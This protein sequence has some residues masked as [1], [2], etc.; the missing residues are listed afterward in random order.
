[1]GNV[2]EMIQTLLWD[3]VQV[4]C[5]EDFCDLVEV[6]GQGEILYACLHEVDVMTQQCRQ[7]EFRVQ[8]PANAMFKLLDAADPRQSLL[9]FE[10]CDWMAS[11]GDCCALIQEGGLQQCGQEAMVYSLE[12]SELVVRDKAVDGLIAGAHG[13]LQPAAEEAHQ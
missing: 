11:Y 10:I 8:L 6:A 12:M 3:P 1:M 5:H 7:P 9:P 13:N 4:G 2:D